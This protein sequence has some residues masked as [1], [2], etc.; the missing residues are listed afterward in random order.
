MKKNLVFFLML[1]SILHVNCVKN[2]DFKIKGNIDYLGT[3]NFFIEL[4]PIHYKYSQKT[5]IPINVNNDFFS[6]SINIDQPTI[7]WLVLQDVRYPM[8]AV[9]KKE[10]DINIIRADFPNKVKIQADHEHGNE[11]YQ[12][13]MKKTEGL[14]DSIK[15]EM[16]KFKM[17]LE[18][19]ALA[20]S[21]KKLELAS[22]HL[23]N[24][25]LHPIFMK[26]MGE[27]LVIKLR[28]TEYSLRFIP[29]FDADKN[30]KKIL[31]DAKSAGFFALESLLAQRAG[32]RDLT[33]YYSRTFGIYDSTLAQYETSL[34]EYDI[35]HLAYDELNKKRLEVLNYID[36]EQAKAYAELFLLAERIGEQPIHIYEPSYQEYL[37][38]YPGYPKYI[39]FATAFFNEIK[40]VSPG[41]PAIP[42][43]IPD[44][45]GAIHT[46]DEY[47]GKFVLLDFWAGWCQPCLAEFPYMNNLYE[48]Y[49]R[50]EL[51]ILGISTE[52]DS[53]VWI[54]DITK[55]E[56][57]WPQLY[58]GDGTEQE[59]FKAYKGGGFLFTYW[60]IRMVKLFVIMMS[61]LLLILKKFWIAF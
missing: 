52:I 34:A 18:N 13:Y 17:G 19:R 44:R 35:K 21:A 8:Y 38:K 32:I 42:F 56:N 6:A 30:R 33:H 55:F 41:Q 11:A 5:R 58:G 54:D 23:K 27:D 22:V 61:D 53:L 39:E 20:L 24:S 3:S 15:L 29:G 4:P 60:L 31:E 59:T 46:L 28:A 7:F 48:K 43:N 9:P 49:S 16:D 12:H 25:P 47:K 57:P 2:S 50:K 36:D 14:D 26:I 45:K 37:Q 1:I 40:S 51:E 10:M